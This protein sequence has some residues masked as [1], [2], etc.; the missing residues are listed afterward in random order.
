[1]KKALSIVLAGLAL[2]AV[3]CTLDEKA[4]LKTSDATA[5]VL[6]SVSAGEDIIVSYTPG[7][8]NM[9]FNKNM[10]V[11]HTLAL[12]SVNGEEVNHPLPDAKDNG[13]T[14]KIAGKKI[15]TALVGHGVA[16]GTTAHIQLV[17]RA[18]I[19]D[20]SKGVTNGFVESEKSDIIKWTVTMEEKPSGGDPYEGWEPTKVWGVIGSIASTGNSW[21]NDEPMY[22]DGEWYVCKGL[23]LTT[24]DEFKFRKDADW[25]TNF[26]GTF[27]VLD[28]EFAVTQDGPNIKVLAD[29][30]YDV[31]LNP[32]ASIAKITKAYE[33][34][35]DYEPSTEWGVI[36]SIA[37][38]GN[39][40]GNDEPML[41]NG[42]WFVC[43]GLSLTTS[44]EFKFRKDA[45][46]G[47]N[48]GGTFEVLDEEFAVTQDG[49][50]IK[51]KEDG[52]YDVLLNPGAAV[53]KVVKAKGDPASGGT[54]TQEPPKSI[55]IDG[56]GSD[57]EGLE[58]VVTL[59]CADGAA[60]ADLKS[61]KI[62]Y[63]DKIYLLVEISDAAVEDGKVRLHM[64]FNGDN[65]SEGGLKQH[66]DSWDIDYMTEGKISNSGAYVPYSTSLYKWAGT[67][68]DPWK[69]DTDNAIATTSNGAGQGN[70]Y[71]L[72]FDYSSYPGGLADEFGFA[73]DIVASSWAT[74]GYL[75]NVAEGECP[76][77]TLKKQ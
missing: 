8:F 12:V 20:P 70:F 19:Q 39:S 40:W 35:A 56:D 57:W 4:V 68:E 7:A 73:I 62:L 11:Y 31:L 58:G 44:D 10:P 16:V 65:N 71:E 6:K 1:M 2:L 72:E 54:G 27:A 21:G 17:V 30:K 18:S 34:Y 43:R 50:N 59:T 69:W 13:S 75:P 15:N 29:G 55:T 67:Q 48:F 51:I 22:T 52:V 9:D 76:K 33:P 63:S 46:W 60:L 74:I 32:E 66:W 5:P 24:S 41:T 23:V 26:G 36:G 38:T 53:A 37:S 14:L 25:G 61:A 77:V 47:T 42:E 3:S 28:E 64:Y 45:D 49:P